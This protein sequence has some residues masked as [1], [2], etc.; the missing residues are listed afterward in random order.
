[1]RGLVSEDSFDVFFSYHSRDHARVEAV[2]RALT[3]RGLRVFLDRWYLTPGQPWP[4]ALERALASCASVAVFIGANGLGPW[5][6]R[7]RDSALDRQGR[8]PGFPV[9]PVLLSRADAGLGFLKANTWVDLSGGGADAEALT[10][11]ANAIR[12]EPPGPH[13]RR[14]IEAV[15]AAVCPYRGLQPFREEDEPYFFGR[16]T[17]SETLSAAVL[18]RAFIAVVG[19]S[20]SGKS[21]VV[22]AGLIP[23]L[24]RGAGGHVWD[25]VTVVPTERPLLSLGAALMPALEPDLSEVDRLVELRKLANHLQDGTVTLHD[26]AARILDKQPG[27]DR[28]LVFVDQWEELYTLCIDGTVRSAFIGQLIDASASAALRVVLT[29]RGDFMGQALDT[30]ALADRLQEGVVTVGPMNRTELEETIVRPAEKIGL[31]FEP[32]LAEM[33]LDDLGDEPGGLPLLEFLLEGLW[34]ERS[35]GVLTHEAYTRLGRVSGAIAHR[36]ED[37]YERQLSEVERQA[38]QRLLMRMVRPGEGVEDTRRRTAL[39]ESDPHAQETIRK[40]AQERLVVTEHD[41]GSG[42]VTVEVAHEALIRRWQRFRTWIDADREFLRTR[43]RVAAQAQLWREEGHSIERLLPPGRPLA[44]GEDLNAKRRAD[45]EPLVID[46]IDASSEAAR[47]A[48]EAKQAAQRRRLRTA[49]LIAAGMTLLALIAIGGGVVAWW[50]RGAAQRNAELAEHN[51]KSAVR[52]ARLARSGEL[53]TRAR[54]LFERTVGQNATAALLALESLRLGG[55]SE[56]QSLIGEILAL[57]PRGVSELPG[58]PPYSQIIQ[59]PDGKMNLVWKHE[60]MDSSSAA[61]TALVLDAETGT[62]RARVEQEGWTAPVLSPGGRWL[63]VGRWGRRFQVIDLQ[64]GARVIDEPRPGLTVAAFSPDGSRLYV[65]DGGGALETRTAPDWGVLSKARFREGEWNN[66]RLDIVCSPDGKML[67]ISFGG[68]AWLGPPG[69]PFR[70]LPDLE[71]YVNEARFDPAGTHILT[72]SKRYRVD[73]RD[74]ATGAVLTKIQRGYGIASWA[75]NPEGTRLAIGDEDG[76]VEVWN[77]QSGDRLLELDH[78]RKN[79]N[80][81]EYTPDGSRLVAAYASGAVRIFESRDGALLHTW[82]RPAAV[83][84]ATFGKDGAVLYLNDEQGAIHRFDLESGAATEVFRPK[85]RPER[86]VVRMLAQEPQSGLLVAGVSKSDGR[87]SWTDLRGIDAQTGQEIWHQA[88]NGEVFQATFSPDGAVFATSTGDTLTGEKGDDNL[89]IRDGATGARLHQPGLEV[90]R[91]GLH[92]TQDS[93]RL[94]VRSK[95]TKVIDPKTGK[96]LFGIGEPGGVDGMALLPDRRTVITYGDD[97]ILRAWDASSGDERWRRSAPDLGSSPFFSGNAARYAQRT[98]DGRGLVVRDTR[99]GAEIA[100]IPGSNLIKILFSYEGDRV[101]LASPPQTDSTTGQPF[102]KV[103]LW[104]VDKANLLR[105]LR[106]KGTWQD[107]A[108]GPDGYARVFILHDRLTVLDS[109]TGAILWE[110]PF[111]RD[112]I[113]YP[114]PLPQVARAPLVIHGSGY[115]SLRDA[116]SGKEIKRFEFG[117]G[118]FEMTADRSKMVAVFVYKEGE[119]GPQ[120]GMIDAETGARLWTAQISAPEEGEIEDMRFSADERRLLVLLSGSSDSSVFLKVLDAADGRVLTTLSSESTVSKFEPLADPDLIVTLDWGNAARIWRLS[121]GE[122]SRRVVHGYSTYGASVATG[123]ARAVTWRE[124]SLRVWDLRNGSEIAHRITEGDVEEA[125]IDPSGHLVAYL[126]A[127]AQRAGSGESYEAILLWDIGED[128]ALRRIPIDGSPSGLAF[129]R[130]GRRLSA[131]V[132]D[133]E[134]R[135]W[136]VASLRSLATLQS[137]TGGKFYSEQQ[138]FSRHGDY[139]FAKETG[140]ASGGYTNQLRVW[141]LSE[142]GPPIEIARIDGLSHTAEAAGGKLLAVGTTQGGRSWDLDSGDL[143]TLKYPG[144]GYCCT[145]VAGSDHRVLD[146]DQDAVRALDVA[147]GEIIEMRRDPASNSLSAAA[148]SRDLSKVFLAERDSRNDELV[149]GAVRLRSLPD[150]REIGQV[151]PGATISEILPV[152][153]DEAALLLGTPGGWIVGTYERALLWRPAKG[154]LLNLNGDN[155]VG[156]AAVS[157]DGRLIVLGEG[158]ENEDRGRDIVR[159]EPRLTV[160]DAHTGGLLRTLAFKEPPTD[161]AFSSDGT[162]M[163]VRDAFTFVAYEVRSWRELRQTKAELGD[164]S[165]RT[166]IVH[167]EWIVVPDRK[168]LRLVAVRSG[169]DVVLRHDRD[170]PAFVR[171]GDD[172]TFATVDERSL[173][174]W[175][176]SPSGKRTFSSGTLGTDPRRGFDHSETSPVVLLA[177]FDNPGLGSG[178]TPIFAGTDNRLF[179][180]G[181][182]SLR[183]FLYRADEIEAEVCRRMGRGLTEDETSVFSPHEPPANPCGKR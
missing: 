155:P 129:D 104:D 43:E 92:F 85:P 78:D 132:G 14:R 87:Y 29:L 51:A 177:K 124:G 120:I 54:A 26:V 12:R 147:S 110:E 18:R 151:R 107:I 125:A 106:G 105:A 148:F 82:E 80:F 134:I 182:N 83:T 7:E 112:W 19:A 159:G 133:R 21:S 127:R 10:I 2:A 128:E 64:T 81:V 1:M 34:T 48:E 4:Q 28:L 144:A 68:G 174:I 157:P 84:G 41:A 49:R 176:V 33:I 126:V 35:G 170:H 75:F 3:E 173:R 32:G 141:N 161:I 44:E 183:R 172:Q 153:G 67:L 66:H 17:F 93:E 168:S 113:G 103:E 158:I 100:R 94:V 135:I 50:Q 88:H 52:Q 146:K 62:V 42:A 131:L 181:E 178:Q 30:R 58:V 73:I 38:A 11:L 102:V 15:R 99:S 46:Y 97:A 145:G 23:R 55:G 130:N 169:E 101:L 167:G 39:P 74:A 152:D 118:G 36:A 149:P 140:A 70:P 142:K 166:A 37:V 122:E 60:G 8:E 108:F 150:G 171:S 59:S 119:T 24:R 22:R 90:Y 111:Q 117:I 96:V 139:Y 138:G 57:T 163:V 31:S 91:N 165:G 9:I 61:G 115:A 69:G 71:P 27:T 160:W 179:V 76:I 86:G 16:A 63:A 164:G 116:H 123:A 121:T 13:A 175:R 143:E 162:V 56:A 25:I 137:T 53:A 180:G 45:L 95:R 47:A 6:Q 156:T 72:I 79:V 20:G 40:L 114:P 136:D 89:T 5:Q 154:Q 98:P 65:A 77:T 109:A